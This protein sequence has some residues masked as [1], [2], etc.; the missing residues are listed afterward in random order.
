MGV[1]MHFIDG[2][3]SELIGHIITYSEDGLNK[4]ITF[5]VN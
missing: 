4:Y 2:V 3:F 5:C 1:K